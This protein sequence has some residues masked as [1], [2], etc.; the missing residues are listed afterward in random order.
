MTNTVIYSFALKYWAL[1]NNCAF[2]RNDNILWKFHVNWNLVCKLRTLWSIEGLETHVW[3]FSKY[4]HVIIFNF[5]LIN[6]IN[7]YINVRRIMSRCCQI[8]CAMWPRPSP[9]IFSNRIRHW[10]IELLMNILSAYPMHMI[11]KALQRPY[12]TLRSC[13]VFFYDVPN[14]IIK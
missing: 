11:L 10:S 13:R 3:D 8:R 5:L 4:N 14:C 7:K 9:T 2:I 1:W 6:N 12:I